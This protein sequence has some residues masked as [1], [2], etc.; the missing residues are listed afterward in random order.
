M[1]EAI[2]RR[3]DEDSN[4]SNCDCDKE[5]IKNHAIGTEKTYKAKEEVV[6]VKDPVVGS[7]GFFRVKGGGGT[8]KQSSKCNPHIAP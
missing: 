7:Q 2:Q 3:Q 1:R 5:D 8:V 6:R 4:T